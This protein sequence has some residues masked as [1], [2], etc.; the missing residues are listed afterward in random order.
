MRKFNQKVSSERVLVLTL[1]QKNTSKPCKSAPKDRFLRLTVD[2][3]KR[4]LRL[5]RE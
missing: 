4:N 3:A 2:K 5:L 1:W